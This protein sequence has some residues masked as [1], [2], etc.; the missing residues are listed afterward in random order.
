MDDLI[1][2]PILHHLLVSRLRRERCLLFGEIG[3][4]FLL[5]GNL[6]LFVSELVL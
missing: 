3:C 2:S 6:E 4:L 5:W 1:R